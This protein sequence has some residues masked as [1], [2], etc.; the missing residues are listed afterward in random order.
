[1][2]EEMK[3]WAGMC[4]FIHV[5]YQ[6]KCET[7]HPDVYAF[8]EVIQEEQTATEVFLIQLESGAHPP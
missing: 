5:H 8:V 7:H 3:L 4:T 6:E 1:M 2:W